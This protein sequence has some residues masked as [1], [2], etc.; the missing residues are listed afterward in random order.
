MEGVERVMWG[1]SDSA[2]NL[3]GSLG[4]ILT[5][6]GA[7]G[8]AF[9]TWV[10]HRARQ[11]ARMEQFIQANSDEHKQNSDKIDQLATAVSEKLDAV[12]DSIGFVRDDVRDMRKDFIRH[13]ENHDK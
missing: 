8:A 9:W 10:K 2:S 3:V 7:A 5:V 11:D 12:N 1:L 13:L 4:T 6:I